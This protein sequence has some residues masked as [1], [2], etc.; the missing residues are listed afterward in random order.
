MAHKEA[1]KILG[2]YIMYKK[3]IEDLQKNCLGT[4]WPWAIF[5]L[6]CLIM[7]TVSTGTIEHQVIDECGADGGM[8]TANVN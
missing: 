7:D 1:L 4:Y 3:I 2:Y 5:S 6:S 8:R